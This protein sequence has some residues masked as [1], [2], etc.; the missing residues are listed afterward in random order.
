M[1]SAKAI[2]R[3]TEWD[4][5]IIKLKGVDRNGG[6]FLFCSHEHCF[7]LFTIQMKLALHY[8]L[9]Y[10]RITVRSGFQQRVDVFVLSAVKEL[11]VVSVEVIQVVME[12]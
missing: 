10:V 2:D 1:E 6:Q 9:S 3:V 4:C 7:C 12:A 11:R 5:D 8:L